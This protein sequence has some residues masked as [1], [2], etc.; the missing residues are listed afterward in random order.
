[1]QKRKDGK[2]EMKKNEYIYRVSKEER[3]IFREVIA[4]VILN[5]KVYVLF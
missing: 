2:M 1:M 5:K 3:S 4:S